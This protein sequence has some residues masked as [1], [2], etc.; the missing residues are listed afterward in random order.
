[1]ESSGGGRRW[2][3]AKVNG[4][5]KGGGLMAE[6]VASVVG[7][8][9]GR[10]GE[11]ARVLIIRVQV[12]DLV[13]VEHALAILPELGEA[14]AMVGHRSRS[15]PPRRHQARDAERCGVRTLQL[16]LW[17]HA[18]AIRGELLGLH[19]LDEAGHALAVR[20]RA[21]AHA[22][23]LQVG[24]TALHDRQ[25]VCAATRALV[26]EALET[27]V[28]A[29]GRE[30]GILANAV[31]ARLVIARGKLDRSHREQ[32]E[33]GDSRAEHCTMWGVVR[34]STRAACHVSEVLAPSCARRGCGQI[35][36]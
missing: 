2:P 21:G 32:G 9:G 19:A 7:T 23:A 33:R 18:L 24:R 25:V 12:S 3:T 36:R 29:L 8:C 28:D 17:Q 16:I 35:G 10:R 26:A 13:D 22:I 6:R 15:Q 31:S 1:M 4:R 20:R 27:G 5:Q 30:I 34:A 14:W 11:C